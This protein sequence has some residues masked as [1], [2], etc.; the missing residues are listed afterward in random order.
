MEA[1]VDNRIKEIQKLSPKIEVLDLASLQPR[2]VK[3]PKDAWVKT[4]PQV[5]IIDGD[6]K[7]TD[8]TMEEAFN[9]ILQ[10][11]VAYECP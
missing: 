4:W 3:G 10:D 6:G 8:D 5:C 1:R 9:S 7:D 2:R 11:Y